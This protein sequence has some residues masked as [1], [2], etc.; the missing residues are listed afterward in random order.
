M[1]V[2]QIM[3]EFGTR[4]VGGAAAAATRLHLD[5]V[6]KMID[7]RVVCVWNG[8]P[9]AGNGVVC[10]RTWWWWLAVRVL[11]VVTRRWTHALGVPHFEQF[12]HTFAP[13]EI[14]VHWIRRDTISWAQ[15]RQCARRTES[16]LYVHLHDLWPLDQPQITQLRPTFVAY[17]DYVASI[18]REKGFQVE[19]RNLIIDATFTGPH[20]IVS[21]PKTILFGCKDG[22]SNPDKGFTDLVHALTLLPTEIKS[23]LV[24]KIFGES[25][26]NTL[27]SDIKTIFLGRIDD[28]ARLRELYTTS[29]CFAF[30]STSETMGMTKLEALACGCPVIA[31]D[32]T[33][34]AEG[35]THIQTGYIARKDD[36][37]DFS[38]GLLKYLIY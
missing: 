19:R 12:L 16:R 1:K 22:R 11:H 17:S 28:P 20:V 24:L 8:E 29:S 9:E 13:E 33:A 37:A 3:Y 31:F 7:S 18:V 26:P 23:N 34:C 5:M 4:N 21:G 36:A 25:A 14:H 27:T 15:L 10:L 35:I 32:R 38:A 6:A 2:L 30:P